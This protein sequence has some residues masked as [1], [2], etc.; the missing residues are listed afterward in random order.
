MTAIRLS[1][2]ALMY[3]VQTWHV[4][5]DLYLVRLQQCVILLCEKA[6]AVSPHNQVQLTHR[7]I[8]RNID[9]YKAWLRQRV[10]LNWWVTVTVTF[11]RQV[12]NASI[13]DLTHTSHL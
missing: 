9:T 7:C 5:A 8:A 2:E 6:I 4:V 13:E 10:R 11:I 12:I 1:V 3:Y